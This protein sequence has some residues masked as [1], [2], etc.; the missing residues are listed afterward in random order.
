MLT[1]VTLS[2]RKGTILGLVG[3]NGAGKSTMM[4]IL[5]GI[6]HRDSGEIWLNDEPFEPKDPKPACSR[7]RVHP[8][9]AEPVFQPYRR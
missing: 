4:N 2:L 3:E 9:G 1:D 5:G 6:H 7:H 8:S